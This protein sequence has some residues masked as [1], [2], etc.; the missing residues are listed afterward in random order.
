MI[1]LVCAN[2]TSEASKRLIDKIESLNLPYPVEIHHAINGFFHKIRKPLHG[3][4]VAVLLASTNEEL[5]EIYHMQGHFLEN[6]R[7]ILILPNSNQHTITLGHK[8][9]PRFLSYA[10]G[11]FTDVSA[12]LEKI[13]K[14]NNHMQ[15]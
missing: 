8:L 2:R 4:E 14:S 12:V 11:D 13:V 15:I 1:V 6:I 9:S 7:V 10:D 3:V 5:L